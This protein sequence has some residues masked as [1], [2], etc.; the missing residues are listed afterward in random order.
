MSAKCHKEFMRKHVREGKL[1]PSEVHSTWLG[2]AR[3]AKHA[4]SPSEAE[5]PFKS[6]A[7]RDA[8]GPAITNKFETSGGT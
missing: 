2:R 3:E 5:L 4:H 7:Q 6:L 8:K 1:R